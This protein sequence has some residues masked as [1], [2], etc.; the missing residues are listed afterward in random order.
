MEVLSRNRFLRQAFDQLEI[1]NLYGETVYKSKLI[2]N[3]E[4][5]V[6]TLAAGLYLLKFHDSKG[7]SIE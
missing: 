2:K 3:T 6:H 4:I 7:N 5:D 1:Y